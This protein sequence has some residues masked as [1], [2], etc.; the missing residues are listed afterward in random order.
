[1]SWKIILKDDKILANAVEK[2]AD[3]MAEPHIEMVRIWAE[4]KDSIPEEDVARFE[5]IVNDIGYAISEVGRLP[6]ELIEHHNSTMS[7]T[8]FQEDEA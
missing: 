7:S 3:D 1:M 5:Q 6:G 4:L 8:D 2:F